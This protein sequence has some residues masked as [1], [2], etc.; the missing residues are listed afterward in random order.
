M[1]DTSEKSPAERRSAFYK[2]WEAHK[3]AGFA[4]T[5]E[6]VN[7]IAAEFGVEAPQLEDHGTAVAHIASP[8]RSMF[9]GRGSFG[10]F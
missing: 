9:N 3:K 10:I 8:G 2:A 6:E 5:Q 1:S 4:E 7:R